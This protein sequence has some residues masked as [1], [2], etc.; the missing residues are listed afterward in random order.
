RKLA[1]HTVYGA[2]ALLEQ[3]DLDS[4]ELR[5]RV[6]SPG[7]TTAAALAVLMAPEAWPTTVPKAIAAAAQRAQ[8]LSS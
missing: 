5:T 6:T 2:G 3:S 8:E 4:A 7:G 1:R